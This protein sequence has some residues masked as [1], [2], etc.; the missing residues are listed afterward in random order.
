MFKANK[1]HLDQIFGFPNISDIIE[2]Y[3]VLQNNE[4][5]FKWLHM[6]VFIYREEEQNSQ[7]SSASH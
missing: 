7:H 5:F 2:V 4:I 6:N 3:E 1:P